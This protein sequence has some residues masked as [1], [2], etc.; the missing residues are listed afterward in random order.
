MSTLTEKENNTP[1]AVIEDND[2]GPPAKKQRYL[3][4][5]EPYL[6][7]IK[8]DKKKHWMYIQCSHQSILILDSCEVLL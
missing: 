1:A 7:V 4:I 3:Y 6:F 8:T 5:D 2:E